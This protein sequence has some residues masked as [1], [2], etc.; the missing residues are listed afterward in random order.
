VLYVN[1]VQIVARRDG[2]IRT[3]PDLSGRRVGVGAPGSGTEVAAR[4]IIE[5]HGL[6]YGDVRP[7]FLSFS[8]VAAQLQDRTLEAGFIMASYPVS[9]ITDA[10]MTVGVRLIPVDRAA[11]DRIVPAYP[12]FRP[13][14]I[15]ANTYRDQMEEIETLGVDNLLV[16]RE[17][18]PETLV[19]ELTRV[20][21]ASLPDL[22][23]A[24]AAARLIDPAQ[25]APTPI[26]LHPGAER[27]YREQRLLP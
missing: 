16:C 21:F 7:D 12:F 19:Y 18:L 26:P 6:Q 23:G 2:A 14:L 15:P 20:F 25:A 8:E 22:A 4:I 24:H 9:A 5:G 3:V 13:V 17:D 1:T 10:A 27:Y 11:I